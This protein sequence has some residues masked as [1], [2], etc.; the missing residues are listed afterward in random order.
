MSIYYANTGNSHIRLNSDFFDPS[1][2]MTIP[3]EK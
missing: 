3:D 1:V 2:K